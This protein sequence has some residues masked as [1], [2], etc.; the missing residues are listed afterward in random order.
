M[1]IVAKSKTD[2]NSEDPRLRRYMLYL[3]LQSNLLHEFIGLHSYCEHLLVM[4]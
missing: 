2:W 1:F 4:A 3:L